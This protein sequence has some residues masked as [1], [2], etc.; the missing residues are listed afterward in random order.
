VFNHQHVAGANR[1][2]FND[3]KLRPGRY[4]LQVV[5]SDANG[6][7]APVTAALTIE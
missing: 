1:F 2:H 3:H 5:A 7:G 4:E 6:P